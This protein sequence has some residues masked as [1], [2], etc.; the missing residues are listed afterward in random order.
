RG[1]VASVLLLFVFPVRRICLRRFLRAPL[2]RTCGRLLAGRH[3]TAGRTHWCRTADHDVVVIRRERRS[4]HRLRHGEKTHVQLECKWFRRGA[5][6]GR[7]R[8]VVRQR[9]AQVEFKRYVRLS[10]RLRRSE[11]HTS[12]LQSREKIVGR[13]LLE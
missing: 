12:E 2:F 9:S 11:E 8:K 6:D 13:R 7:S 5:V 3:G 10:L 1:A 4:Y